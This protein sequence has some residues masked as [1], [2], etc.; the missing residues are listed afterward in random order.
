[1]RIIA[2]YNDNAVYSEII[3]D[4]PSLSH[5]KHLESINVFIFSIDIENEEDTGLVQQLKDDPRIKRVNAGGAV[6]GTTI[7]STENNSTQG[8]YYHLE[9]INKKDP[10]TA[11]ANPDDDHQYSY[12][13]TGTGV[14]VYVLDSGVNFDHPYLQKVAGAGTETKI[15][16]MPGHGETGITGLYLVN[17]GSNYFNNGL[18]VTFPMPADGNAYGLSGASTYRRATGTATLSDAGGAYGSVIKITITDFGSGYDVNKKQAI[19]D[20]ILIDDNFNSYTDA[21]IEITSIGNEE[22]NGPNEGAIGS[23]HGTKMALV[24]GGH[25]L[26]AENSSYNSYGDYGPGVAKE[27][28]IWSVKC[29]DY[30]AEGTDEAVLTAIDAV[31]KH[32]KVGEPTFK[33]GTPNPSI[34]NASFAHLR[35]NSQ[36]PDYFIDITGTRT[37]NLDAINDALKLATD[38]DNTGY[39]IGANGYTYP[40]HVIVGAGNGYNDGAEPQETAAVHGPMDAR[41]NLAEISMPSSASSNTDRRQGNPITVSATK[42][43]S[44]SDIEPWENSNYGEAVTIWAPGK[45]IVHPIWD[46]NIHPTSSDYAASSGTSLS[47]A[48]V[49]GLLALRLQDNTAESPADAKAWLLGDGSTE[50]I[51]SNLMTPVDLNKPAGTDGPLEVT[52]GSQSI[53]VSWDNHPL[54]LW[55]KVQISGGYRISST[56]KLVTGSFNL[57]STGLQLKDVAGWRIVTATTN[58]TFTFEHEATITSTFPA[59]DTFGGSHDDWD[60]GSYLGHVIV[61]KVEDTHEYND[62]V[63]D[64]QD[65]DSIQQIDN[66]GTATTLSY[67]PVSYSTKSF[68]FNPYQQY[69]TNWH[70]SGG[71]LGTFPLDSSIDI[72]LSA[73]INTITEPNGY[74]DINSAAHPEGPFSVTITK[75]SGNFPTGTSFLNGQLS[76]SLDTTG[77]FGFTLTATN[78]YWTEDIVYSLTVIACEVPAATFNLTGANEPTAGQCSSFG[79]IAGG[80]GDGYSS[81]CSPAS[82]PLLVNVDIDF[83]GYAAATPNCNYVWRVSVDDGTGYKTA[84][85]V[86]ALEPPDSVCLMLKE[87]DFSTYAIELDGVND[88]IQVDINDSALDFGTGSFSISMWIKTTETDHAM[89]FSSRDDNGYIWLESNV[90]KARFSPVSA[91]PLLNSGDIVVNDGAWHHIVVTLNAPLNT[92]SIYVDGVLDTSSQDAAYY[93]VETNNFGIYFLIGQHYSSSE[94]WYRLDGQIANLAIWNES[95]SVSAISEIQNKITI[96]LN[97]NRGGYIYKDNLVG[98]WKLGEGDT[99]PVIL[100]SSSHSNAGTLLSTTTVSSTIVNRPSD[101]LNECGLI[102][103]YDIKLEVEKEDTTPVDNSIKSLQINTSGG[104]NVEYTGTD[105]YDDEKCITP[106]GATASECGLAIT[107]SNE[108]SAYN[109]SVPTGVTGEACS[110]PQ[111][112]L[113]NPLNLAWVYVLQIRA[114][115]S[116]P[117]NGRYRAYYAGTGTQPTDNPENICFPVVDTYGWTDPKK[118]IILL[119][120]NPCH[121]SEISTEIALDDHCSGRPESEFFL[122]DKVNFNSTGGE[123][124][125]Y[126]SC[127]WTD[128]DTTTNVGNYYGF[129]STGCAAPCGVPLIGDVALLMHFNDDLSDSSGNQIPCTPTSVNL[130]ISEKKFGSASGFFNGITSYIDVTATSAELDLSGEF[131]IDFWA[132]FNNLSIDQT[133]FSSCNLDG[134]DTSSSIGLELIRPALGGGENKFILNVQDGSTI[135]SYNLVVPDSYVSTIALNRFFHIALVRDGSNKIKLYINGV[136]S[137]S[138]SVIVNKAFDHGFNDSIYIGKS[139]STTERLF[140]GYIDEFRIVNNT[141]FWSSDFSINSACFGTPLTAFFG[142]TPGTSEVLGCGR[143]LHGSQTRVCGASGAWGDPDECAEFDDCVIGDK[144]Y[145]DCYGVTSAQ[146]CPDNNTDG[147]TAITWLNAGYLVGPDTFFEGFLIAGSDDADPV[148]VTGG[149]GTATATG[150]IGG[151]ASD[152]NDGAVSG[153]TAGTLVG[154]AVDDLNEKLLEVSDIANTLLNLAPPEAPLANSLTYSTLGTSVKLTMTTNSAWT[155]ANNSDVTYSKVHGTNTLSDPTGKLSGVN[156]NGTFNNGNVGYYTGTDP[157]FPNSNSD[158]ASP[159]EADRRLGA[160]QSSSNITMNINGLDPADGTSPSYNYE[161]DSFGRADKGSLYLYVNGVTAAS[162][163]DLSTNSAAHSS[164]GDNGSSIY[165]GELTPAHFESGATFETY[166]HRTDSTVTVNSADMKYGWNYAQIKHVID[167]NTT[168]Y[169]NYI[170]WL[171]DNNTTKI[172]ITPDSTT[173]EA[174][175]GGPLSTNHLSGVRYHPSAQVTYTYTINDAYRNFYSPDEEALAWSGSGFATSGTDK[176][177]DATGLPFPSPQDV[178]ATYTRTTTIRLPAPTCSSN[179]TLGTGVSASIVVK[180][181]FSSLTSDPTS[182]GTVSDNQFLVYDMFGYVDTCDTEIK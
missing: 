8:Y 64:A 137:D 113:S 49:T 77:T 119:G 36:N 27:A 37:D 94:L 89:L 142:C 78:G 139:Q 63:N 73:T 99:L 162:M 53:T 2:R 35:P 16:S 23:G 48:L 39:S 29:L 32:N 150:I 42:E 33:G 146:I 133:L 82:D 171:R 74:T 30:Q 153:W 40:I 24:I 69:Q 54:S 28:N 31:I 55:D 106:C 135:A 132:Q 20:D 34:I 4:Y 59:A 116:N 105:H 72:D 80:Y 165:V 157:Y 95:L 134:G 131:T 83:T 12:S 147:A 15:N 5:L 164:A 180:H 76:G 81:D 110:T 19:G 154:V 129:G 122:G 61:S 149:G 161:A 178:S 56:E 3:Q 13:N 177:P 96:D 47:T 159:P 18:T 62:G 176:M 148:E 90:I 136:P 115:I 75:K 84:K 65:T 120:L 11:Q 38:P 158:N 98:W 130:D 85:E 25:N 108:I 103:C 100:D 102:N 107:P 6:S 22:D 117:I 126:S 144:Q 45:S 167:A 182:L 87:V 181:P 140:N 170:T 145:I 179:W 7:E 118:S 124:K 43:A 127:I 14:D 173:V 141:A 101:D 155:T 123:W 114:N 166:Q 51:V 71:D 50:D 58:N 41:W 125:V 44:A 160:F 1:M 143:N 9:D 70:T 60:S 128:E 104:F 67:L 52:E 174:A 26:K 93:G 112:S 138:N 92:L 163:T 156:A 175:D 21:S 68:V 86:T 57:G 111:V 169:S 46:I 152:Y 66:S 17:G 109:T 172:T 151:T 168:V 91:Q 79:T 97:Q 121:A 88:Y 10:I